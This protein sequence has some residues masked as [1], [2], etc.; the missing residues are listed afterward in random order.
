MDANNDALIGQTIEDRY[1]IKRRIGQG[2]MGVVYLAEHTRVRIPVALKVLHLDMTQVDEAVARFK[3]EAIVAARVD[4]P[5][6]V[7]ASDFG[8]LEDG[9]FYLVLEYVDGEVLREVLNE[10]AISV[11]RA[12][13]IAAQIAEALKA[14]HDSG[15]THRDLKPEN[16]MLLDYRGQT[17]FVKVFDFG[18][19]RL[20]MDALPPDLPPI[21]KFGTLFGT[22]KYMAPEQVLQQGVDHRADLYSL[23][24]LLYEMLSGS[25]PFDGDDMVA[26]LSRQVTEAPPPLPNT[27]PGPVRRL[28]MK[29]IDKDPISRVQTAG[30]I[31]DQL[32]SLLEKR[33]RETAPKLGLGAR[34]QN[35]AKRLPSLREALRTSAVALFATGVTALL[36]VGWFT[37]YANDTIF[38]VQTA[39][40][41]PPD[42]EALRA[43]ALRGDWG[44]TEALAAR[45]DGD[46]TAEDWLALGHSFFLN[47][48]NELTFRTY[49]NAVAL[50]ANLSSSPILLRD[51]RKLADSP[52]FG[53][54]AL[55]FAATLSGATGPDLLFDVW[56][57][58]PHRT[59]ETI[60]ARALLSRTD[61]KGRQSPALK[62]AIAL[63]RA[64]E[65]EDF[66]A[67]LERAA[68]H[69]DSRALR[70]LERLQG[71]RG[72]GRRFEDDC[73]PCLRP[74]AELLTQAVARA[75]QHP[76]IDFGD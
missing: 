11:E 26:V 59:K 22:P 41:E 33:R 51:L 48:K 17:D 46:R 31:R 57:G 5:H 1:L 61:I 28:V 12:L 14:A 58:T 27:L 29:L 7:S 2:G 30:E 54:R 35:W 34:A 63:R 42:W 6:L 32:L 25:P 69:A 10:G 73:Y 67:L 36:F 9:S 18:M 49:N 44:A 68:A 16:V 23:G 71:D 3:R 76:A 47:G 15:I 24:I 39:A 55:E 53:E 38:N 4:D 75:K 66:L 60:L 70:P 43:R 74:Q 20:W 62:L 40:P 72:C 50:D 8:T 21:T 45:E 19:A 56:A 64:K 13:A 65:C 52:E 37:S